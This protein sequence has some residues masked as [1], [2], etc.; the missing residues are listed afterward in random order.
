MKKLLVIHDRSKLLFYN[1]RT[2]RTPVQIELK[3]DLKKI[4]LAMKMGDIHDYEI[5]DI[6][7]E[8]TEES[9]IDN[10]LE[11][12]EVFIANESEPI[13]AGPLVVPIPVK[14]IEPESD[15]PIIE[16]ISDEENQ[17]DEIE[18][19]ESL[20]NEDEEEDDFS[21]DDDEEDDMPSEVKIEELDEIE[22]PKTILEKLMNGEQ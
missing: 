1:N 16:L 12:E 3:N 10:I 14:T 13:E 6:E 5:I 15:P 2:L 9:I 17:I 4:Q 20:F 21:W 8:I 22:K 19:T 11:S 7:E 18:L